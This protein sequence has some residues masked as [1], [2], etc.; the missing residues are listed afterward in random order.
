[1]PMFIA[2][3][4]SGKNSSDRYLVI[5]SAWV[6]K[7]GLSEFEKETTDLRLK[8]KCWGEI[9]LLKVKNSMS[10][11]IFKTYQDFLSQAFQNIPVSFRCIVIKKSLLD[12][13]TFHDKD[14]ELVYFKFLYLLL[15]R[16]GKKIVDTDGKKKLHIVFDKF[17]QSKK[18]KE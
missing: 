13:P 9:E 8:R 2:C 7:S 17:E 4:E 12:M 15:S 18:S 3:D 11:A 10:D 6:S 5:G 1:M 14:E 16:H